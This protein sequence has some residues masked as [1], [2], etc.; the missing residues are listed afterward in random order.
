MFYPFEEKSS[1]AF[2][3]VVMVLPS[4]D[5]DGGFSRWQQQGAKK[6]RREAA[7]PHAIAGRSEVPRDPSRTVVAK[8]VPWSASEQD[9]YTFFGQSGEVRA[10][11]CAGVRAGACR[12]A[13]QGLWG[14]ARVLCCSA[15]RQ[16]ALTVAEMRDSGGGRGTGT[17]MRAPLTH[18]V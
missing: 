9:L 4:Q 5:A 14:R 3:N 6:A 7:A 16:R 12:A 2:A 15:F 10:G 17:G 11:S 13:R 18:R 1:L 8:N